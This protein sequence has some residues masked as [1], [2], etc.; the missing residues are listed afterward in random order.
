MDT[1]GIVLLVFLYL[2]IYSAYFAMILLSNAINIFSYVGQGIG[3][4]AMAKHRGIENP[5]LAWVP[6]ANTWMVGKLSDHYRIAT[7]GEDPDLRKRLLIQK[8]AWVGTSAVMVAVC[9][10]WYFGMIFSMIA[11]EA[12]YVDSEAILMPMAYLFLILLV[13]LL[14]VYTITGVFYFITQYKALFDVYR[15]ADPKS[16]TL[17][18]VLSFFSN[19]AMTLGILLNRY[20]T[21]GMPVKPEQVPEDV[22][23][24]ASEE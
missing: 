11:M 20:K 23:E 13:I 4:S 14:I 17:F 8:I 12:F 22:L 9:L 16:S 24:Q 2:I 21:L 19:V 10:V 18:F 6:M 7:T 5:W 1:V 15:S 3:L